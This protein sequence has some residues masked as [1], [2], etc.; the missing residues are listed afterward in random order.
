[1]LTEN[2]KT[3]LH[4]QIL[5]VAQISRCRVVRID[6]S[7]QLLSLPLRAQLQRIFVEFISYVMDTTM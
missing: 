6:E 3:K 1:M 2:D 5:I 4:K 7:C